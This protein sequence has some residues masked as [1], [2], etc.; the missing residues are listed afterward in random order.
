MYN[1]C[2][3]DIVIAAPASVKRYGIIGVLADTR[4]FV[5]K[6]KLLE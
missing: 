5:S 2:M 1:V 6:G 3:T 4:N